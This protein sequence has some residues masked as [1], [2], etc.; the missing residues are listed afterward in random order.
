MVF[1]IGRVCVKIAG[2]DSNR[3]C[4]V[5]D[6][7]DE[8]FVLIDG[9]VRRRKCNIMHLEPLNTV[10]KIEKGASHSG[11][12]KEFKELGFGVWETKP[13]K[14]AEKP[15]KIRRQKEKQPV[16]EKEKK[17]EKKEAEETQLEKIAETEEKPKKKVVKKVKKE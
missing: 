16:E 3:K 11:I 15:K 14:T 4:V 13:R 8:R 7:I 17:A 1:E 6:N 10:I 2:R 12:V 9:D 5:V